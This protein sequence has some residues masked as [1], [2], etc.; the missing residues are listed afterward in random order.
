MHLGLFVLAWVVG[1]TWGPAGVIGATSLL[2]LAELAMWRADLVQFDTTRRSR[3][4]ARHPERPGPVPSYDAVKHAIAMGAHSRREFDFN[5]RRRL[6]RIAGVRL[7]AEHGVDLH[8]D[9]PAARAL[10]GDEAWELVDPGRPVSADRT[11]GGVSPHTLVRIV[12][13]LESL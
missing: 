1:F 13:R 9:P 5:M 10:L 8:R 7:D 6:E 12:D 3:R 4:I 2:L 11:R